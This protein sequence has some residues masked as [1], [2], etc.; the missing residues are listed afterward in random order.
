MAQG[1]NYGRF[2]PLWLYMIQG[3]PDL[4][5]ALHLRV[6]FWPPLSSLLLPACKSLKPLIPPSGRFEFVKSP[7]L[8]ICIDLPLPRSTGMSKCKHG[9]VISELMISHG[10]L[11]S[12]MCPS[13]QKMFSVE[14]K[15]KINEI[16]QNFQIS[17]PFTADE[18]L[19]GKRFPVECKIEKKKKKKTKKYFKIFWFLTDH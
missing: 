18:T 17:M 9:T 13:R 5:D 19:I 16:V 6:Q 12:K 1:K 2:S 10:D 14:C 7:I 4:H 11:Q 3:G 15:I 8:V